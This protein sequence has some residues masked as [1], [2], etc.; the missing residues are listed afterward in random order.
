MI[1][2]ITPDALNERSFQSLI[3]DYLIHEQDYVESF[4]SSYNQSL[5]ID[6]EG[7]FSFL[8]TTQPKETDR[9]KEIYKT[10]YRN[11]VLSNLEREL[12]TRGSIDVLKHGIK[13]YGVKLD[14]AYFKPPT[15]LNPDQYTLYQQNILSV[16]EELNYIEEKRIDLVLFLNGIPIVTMELKNSFTG[17][18][19][20]NAIQQYKTDRSHTEPLFMF[21]ERAIVHFA[22]DTDEAY[23]TTRLNGTTTFFLPFNKGVGDRA[24]NP[25]VEGKLNTHY[26]W[27]EILAKDMLLE[28]VQKF[29]YVERREETLDNGDTIIKETVIFP[30]YHQLYVVR[31]VLS[32]AKRNGSGQKYL[33]QH[34]AG[35]GKTN[36]I[37]W[38]AH[39]L[40]SLHDI[41]NQ[42]IFH[43]VIVITDR[44]VL[45]QQ[46]QDS[47][48]QL[49]HKIGLVAKIDEDSNQLAAELEKGTKIIISTIQKFSFILEKCS[50]TKGKRYAIIID[51]AHSSTSG[52]NISALKESL[53]LDE[54][55]NLAN[56][57][58]AGELDAEDKINRELE[59]FVDQS[60][61]SIFAFTATPKGTT[62]RLFGEKRDDDKYHPTHLYS[63][64]Q[65]IE[66]GFILDVLKNYMTYKMFYNVNKKIEDDPAFSKSKATRSIARYVSLHPHNISQ[67]TEIMI[68]HFKN[69]TMK[70][71]GGEAKAMLVTSSRLHAVRY[72]LAFDEYIRRKGYHDL[73]TLVAFSGTVKDGGE[74]YKETKMNNGVS[75]S[76]L[77]DKF[78]QEDSRILI[79]ASKYQTGFDQPK[80]HTM[81]VDKKLSGIKAVQ[82]LSRLNRIYPGKEDT[83]VLDFVNEPEEI[84]EAFKPFYRVTVLNNDIE[85]NE[86]YTIERSIYDHQVINKDDVQLFTD[87]FYKDK[88]S[89]TDI[90]IMN[91][92]VNHSVDRLTDY[93]KEELIE[94]KNLISKFMNLYMLI[95][96][97]APIVDSDLHRLSIY[98]RYLIK[99]INIENTGGVDITDKVLLQYYKLEKRTEGAI[100]LEYGQSEG[101]GLYVG[102]GGHVEEEPVDYLSNIIG[103]LNK[104]HGTKFSESEKLAVEQISSNL[105]AN[106]DLELKAQ[107]N[108]Y[109]VFKHAFE[110]TFLEGVIQEYDKNEMFYGKIL[111]DDQ[112]R[113]NLMELIMFETYSFFRKANDTGA[114]NISY[115]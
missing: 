62:L 82:T 4:N 86:I 103:R 9:L 58:E 91:H 54:T 40:A 85:P 101:V 74:E 26:I 61:V 106:K 8:E 43:G 15:D 11:K 25:S 41:H 36:S 34:S 49:E 1:T 38:L 20:K 80:L 90:G 108:T 72:K 115:K 89:T 10:N 39:R 16:T 51:E 97:V 71:I 48:Y 104:K 37:T 59:K 73:K 7:L 79:V 35:S 112:F 76:Q 107:V 46:L 88:H 57:E 60:R 105:K 113:F 52:K 94:F 17:Q 33:I 47:I 75:E 81:Y 83:F 77:P 64:R 99:K 96:Q 87:I 55:A 67:K 2:A 27:E 24:G 65:A 19:Y 22:M 14:L 18:T 63:M 98:L 53:S 12:R 6:V 3:K 93:S 42:I 84:L 45:D 28:I 95:I 23:M 68:E 21:K 69:F 66:E 78:D 50:G 5:A 109:E 100:N 13:D 92:C 102:S 56:K 32:H 29:T 110:P 114:K 70:K 44:K 111:K 30:R 31:K